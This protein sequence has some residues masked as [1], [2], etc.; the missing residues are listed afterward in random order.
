M[1]SLLN[2]A[3]N[4]EQTAGFYPFS[5]TNSL[6]FNDGSSNY[7][8]RTLNGDRQTYTI[9][10][11]YKRGNQTSTTQRILPSHE[12][13]STYRGAVHIDTNQRLYFEVGGSSRFRLI[14][15]RLFRDS[16]AW[17]NIVL[18]ADITNTTTADKLRMY[19]NGTRITGNSTTG[20]GGGFNTETQPTN[21]T[22]SA[23]LLNSNNLHE[24]S[25]RDAAGDYLD[26][27]LTEF[28][29]IDNQAL[30]AS[31]FGET[32]SGVW[33]PKDTSGLSFGTSG[34]RLEFKQTGTGTASSS[35]IGADTSGNTNHFSTNSFD[36]Y[37]IM[38]DSPT[39]NF[40]T[41]AAQ[42]NSGLTL[43]EGGLKITTGNSTQV[44]SSTMAVNASGKKFY[45]EVR[46]NSVGNGT[47]IGIVKASVGGTRNYT[48]AQTG[49]I[50]YT[51]ISGAIFSNISGAVEV[52]GATYTDT[53]VIG[54]AVDGGNGTAQFFKNGVSQGT[55]TEATIAT[56]DYL[57]YFVN[58]SSSGSS[59]VHFNFGHDST[60]NGTETIATNADGNGLG[61]F[62]HSVP[63]GF[64][65]MCAN[66]IEEP[67]ITP[68]TDNIAE[69]YF[70]T[71][72]WLG[73]GSAQSLSD[74]QFS[75][76]FVWLK[77]RD[78]T[79]WNNLMDTVRTNSS[80]M[81]SN[82]RN[83]EDDGSGIITSFDSNG[84]SVGSNSNSNRVDDNFV[85]WNWLAGA[86]DTGVSNSN[87]SVTS[88]VSANQ[89]SGFSIVAYTGTGSAT[90]IGH[91]LSKAPELL[92]T[93]NRDDGTK[94]WVTQVTA[95]GNN[96]LQ[97][98][99][100]LAA[101]SGTIYFND[102]AP[103]SSVF[104]VG[105]AGST[106]A[107]TDDFIAYCWHSVD[108]YS[109]IGTYVGNGSAE[110]TVVYTG[111]RPAWIMIKPSSHTGHWRIMDTKREIINNGESSQ[112]FANLPD[113]SGDGAEVTGTSTDKDILSNGFQ[114]KTS[115]TSMNTTN[116]TYIYM[117]FA[118]MPF[119]YANAR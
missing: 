39:N 99:E 33:I 34:F 54:V 52:S 40:A 71:M 53:D 112:L 67:S 61:E 80:R 28:N 100:T 49:S 70:D 104:S 72:L 68:L 58:A 91:G 41:L 93:K 3:A 27:Y 82:N 107:S 30:D 9:S 42:S 81:A 50:Y 7:L 88:T 17:Y 118:E 69:D 117:A 12:G 64:L 15:N 43:F 63:S 95:L 5:I 65:T 48:Y 109:K 60:F 32:K 73:T 38:P 36:A 35:T 14:S 97:L 44:V 89:Q 105:T 90:T 76:N 45:F 56:E 16:A 77:N 113:G 1:S 111:F 6:R 46:A 11:W 31:S 79:D 23:G 106:N 19:V 24:I 57:A 2:I 94:G 59:A 86:S 103:T 66:N 47:S 4:T 51:G 87:G 8:Q 92:I 26:G 116:G 85:A 62:H 84:F 102:T 20:T 108:G 22:Y 18:V 110:G 119:K 78:H 114:I 101:F 98:E 10:F 25:G 75:P 96:Y 74:L 29:F 115:T 21:E 13:S 37:D 55:V 83:A